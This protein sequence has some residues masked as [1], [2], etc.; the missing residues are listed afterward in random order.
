METDEYLTFKVQEDINHS[1][2][3]VNIKD[4]EISQKI[5]YNT[6]IHKDYTILTRLEP[7]CAFKASLQAAFQYDYNIRNIIQFN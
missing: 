3:H 1:L 4:Y 6:G 2:I 7:D 5:E